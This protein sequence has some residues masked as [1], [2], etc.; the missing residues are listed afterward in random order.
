MFQF[1]WKASFMAISIF[2][3]ILGGCSQNMEVSAEE[4]IH[5]A[6]ESEKEVSEYYGKSEM[7]MFDGEEMIEESI[8]EEFVSG[9][10]RKIVTYGQSQGTEEEIELLNNGEKMVMY[11]KSNKTAQE[12]DTTAFAD[13]QFTPKEFFQRML[14]GMRDSHDYEVIG[15]E[16]MLD[17]D[18]FH[19]KL[20]AKEADSLMGD[21]E[22]WVDKETWMVLKTISETGD[23]KMEST[24]T[25]LDLSPDFAED[26]FTLDI[27]DDVEITNMEDIG[28][29]ES[30]S[31]EEAEEE[32]G[33]AFYMFP[34]EAYTLNDIEINNVETVDRKELNLT[35]ISN[36]DIP[37]FFLS[38]F[39][40][41]EDME[42]EASNVQIR[43]NVTQYEE[44]INAYYWDEDGLRYVLMITNPDIEEEILELTEDMMLSSEL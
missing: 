4:I 42:I 35:Y 37:M 16:E 39:E 41:P 10:D 22:L 38:I 23:S 36:D 12:M 5:N 26:T 9:N 13:Y 34:E 18:T 44:S 19:I 11:N 7:K 24:Y 25:E 43:G 32:L 6:I 30:I 28:S 2:I 3:L 21:M 1:R 29:T 17:R 40:A 31:A 8:M 27:P 14:A 33:K 15:E 20:E